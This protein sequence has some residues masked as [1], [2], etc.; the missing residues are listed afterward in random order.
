M[1]ATYTNYANQEATINNR[2]NN[3][4]INSITD[5]F[6]NI[7]SGASKGG[8]A[9]AVIGGVKSA[10]D[11]G[12]KYMN[13]EYQNNTTARDYAN[14]ITNITSG[15][16]NLVSKAYV[17]ALGVQSGLYTRYAIH[18]QP[19]EKKKIFADLLQ[20]SYIYN[21]VEPFK[22]YDNRV[23]FNRIRI[24][25]R[26]SYNIM[27]HTLMH[28]GLYGAL[29]YAKEIIAWLVGGIEIWKTIN[30]QSK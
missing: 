12:Q 13:L 10:V 7:V 19:W 23:I 29:E 28:N 5:A 26:L 24:D 9:G 22:V 8:V 15:S 2:N 27:L 14:Q 21:T 11:I 1:K 3:F 25:P 17:S 6:N 16:S 4:A 20:T 30:L 18:L